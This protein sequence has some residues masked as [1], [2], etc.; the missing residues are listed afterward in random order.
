MRYVNKLND[1]NL[2]RKLGGALRNKRLMKPMTIMEV[3]GTHTMAIHRGGIPS[4]LPDGMKLLSG[5]GC[6]VCVTPTSYLDKAIAIARQNDVI[7]TTFGDMLRVP[8]SNGSLAHLRTD[9]FPVE[10]V[11]SPAQ[12]VE[13][14]KD[15]PT[16]QVIFL[17]VGFETTIPT[18]AAS[19]KFARDNDIRN[20]SVLTAHKLV[21][22]ALRA[23]IS[24]PDLSVDGFLLPG[25]VSIVLGLEPYRFIA[26]DYNRA[27]VIAGFEPADVMQ[28]LLMLAKQIEEDNQ[29]VEIQYLRVVKPKGNHVAREII[30][31][32]YEIADANWRGFGVIPDSGLVI[33]ERFADFDAERRFPVD[34]AEVAEP[35]GCRCGEILQGKINPTECGLFET[36]C[37]PE[38]PVG[39]CMV[40]SEGT[41]A[42]YYKHSRKNIM[43]RKIEVP[44]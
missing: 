37:N 41:C 34:V 32:V 43:S 14:A 18:I 6:P 27:C 40:S 24:D 33:R 42:A 9:G 28:S 15:N 44:V 10:V 16:K 26:D 1:S 31:E 19:I 3:C 5:P 2:L 22:P 21:I 17:G 39:A 11:Y 38:H 4:L 13:M 23:L 35:A 25:H 7:L 8:S 20:Y 29:S 12:A 30:D 36:V